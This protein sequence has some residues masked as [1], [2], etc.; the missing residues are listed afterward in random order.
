MSA[1]ET[2]SGWG[3]WPSRACVTAP[4]DP[5]TAL[6]LAPE[7]KG[8]VA[9]G[10]GRSYGDPAM[11]PA[12]TLKGC[13]RNRMLSFDEATGEL[14]AE[15]G[16]TSEEIIDV[17]LPRGWFLPVTPGTKF[18]TL[19]GLVAADAHGKN[20]HKTGSFG[21]HLLWFDLLCAD[22]EIRRCSPQS[23]ADL[24]RATIGGMGLT[25]HI[26]TVGL[27]LMPVPSAWVR[28][29]TIPAPNLDAAIEAFE[30]NYDATYSVAWIDCLATGKER[31][32]SLV[33]VGEHA[34]PEELERA[35]RARP[36]A[37]PRRP[38]KTMPLDAPSWALNRYTIK[39]FNQVYYKAGAAKP[40]VEVVD[41]DRYF[42][43]LDAIL[44][45]NR[46]Y[47]SRGFA[48]YQCALPLETSRDG[49]L[50]Q[51]EA[52]SEAGLG[53][54]LAVLKRF[55]PGAPDRPLSFPIEGYTLALDFALSP[56]ALTLL[57]QLDEITVACGGRIY[58]AKDS[59]MS[60][61]TL[62]AGYGEALEAF[63]AVRHATGA[64]TA[65]TSLLSKRLDL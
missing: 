57:D 1:K 49:L 6:E 13:G 28:Q 14:V 43:P 38:V 22:G 3:R 19:G 48:Q 10:M 34:E 17:F 56:K 65:F 54:F 55:G 32:R 11:N 4:L 35:Y 44:E 20:H 18:V 29:R 45:W 52:I 27:K 37:Y 50:A 7:G 16:V 15:A 39:A 33:L 42:Y 36:Y 60:Q 53:S 5:A 64:D 24:F 47:G 31:G 58:L 8:A 40:E 41:F 46:L 63:R 26:L 30:E 51:L 21:D 59:R 2:L 12:M 25:G 9:R 62:R 61:S 23:E